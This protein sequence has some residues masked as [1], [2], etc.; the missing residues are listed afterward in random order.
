[1]DMRR[2]IITLLGFLP[3]ALLAQNIT[4][5][6]VMNDKTADGFIENRMQTLSVDDSVFIHPDRICY[7]SRCIQIEGKDVF[8]FSGAFH[9]FR[10]PQALWPDRFRKLKEGGFNCVETYI[11]WN[12]HERKM[13]RSPQ[14]DS[15][16]DMKELDDFLKMAEDFGLYVIVRP[17]PYICAEWS[18]GGFPQWIMRKKP[19][20]TTFDTWL[21]SNDP[22]FMRWNEHWYRAVCRVVAPHQLTR[23]EKG[24]TGVIFFQVENEFNRI[25]WFPKEAKKDYLIQ[26]SQIVRK[27][28][29]DVPVITCWTDEARNVEVGVLNGV[30]DMV[31]SYPR[32]EIEKNFGRLINQQLHTQPGKPLISGE[33]QGG[34][35]SEVGGK[36]SWEQ[37]GLMP[38]QTQNITLYALQRGFCGINYYMTVGGTNFDDWGARQMTTTYDYAA[39]IA[40]NGSTNERYRRFRG[41]SHLLKEHGTRIARADVTPVDYTTTDPDVKLVLRQASNGDRYYFLRTEEHTRHHFGTIQTSDLAFDFALEPF[42]SMIY[43]LPVGATQ[44]DWLPELPGTESRPAVKAD[45]IRLECNKRIVDPLPVHWK[46]LKKGEYLDDDGIYGRHFAYYRTYAPQGKLLEVGRIGHKLIN[47]TDAD[48]VL[49][50]VQGKLLPVL[51]EDAYSASYQL[52]GDSAVNEKV[53][54]IMLFESKGLHHHTKKIV[55]DYWNMGIGYVKCGGKELALEYAYTEEEHGVSLSKGNNLQ[56]NAVEGSTDLYEPLLSWYSSTFILPEQPHGIWYPYHLRLEHSGNGFIYVNGHCIGRCWEKGPQREY[57]IPECWLNIGGENH[58][59]VSLRPTASGADIQKAEIIPVTWVAESRT[60]ESQTH[61]LPYSV[62][63]EKRV[64]VIVSMDAANEVDDAYAIVHALLTPQFIVKGIVAAHFKDRVPQSM[65]KSYDEVVRI[66]EK[67]D[68]SDKVALLRGAPKPLDDLKTPVISEGAELIIREALSEDPRPLYV[69]CGGPL[70]DVASAYLKNPE[71]ASRITVV[72]S[73]GGAYPDN[74]NEYN[75]SNDVNSVNVIFSSLM[76][77]WQI[78]SNVYSMVRVGTAEIALKVKPCGSIGDYLYK[79]MLKFNEDKKHVKGW[80]RGEDWTFGDSPGISLILNPNQHT[81]YYDMVPAP[82]ISSDLKYEKM[83]GNREIRVYK[84]VN[85]RIVLDDFFAKL[86][87]AYGGK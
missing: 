1:M 14:D 63:E 26:L 58:L 57:Y 73:G 72:W 15:C 86:Q 22:E 82:R 61:N 66:V 42:G 47:G 87:L 17:G 20:K 52:P 35:M 19:S 43:Y 79:T 53:E 13:P 2:S 49:V 59:A 28:G 48:E 29:I 7:D 40:E 21:Q 65:E 34:W 68:L 56:G 76:N 60:A 25:K 51:K 5:I 85:G 77:V 16:L 44:G 55:E 12:W 81:D 37:E 54:V 69:L 4:D 9:Y 64:R 70:T 10:V 31:N 71:I 11:P 80:P 30:V 36:L 18:G 33:L 45:T 6:A 75:L 84:H 24:W 23:K 46:K 32:W 27:Y 39:A 38:V 8:V 50:S 78:P 62:P 74:A 41:L 3:I 83:D 67:C